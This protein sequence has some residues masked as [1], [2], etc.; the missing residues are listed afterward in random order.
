MKKEDKFIF[1]TNS[2]IIKDLLTQY[3]NT[4]Y[5]FCELINN[6]IQAKAN[7]IDIIIDYAKS[8]LTKVFKMKKN[9]F[10]VY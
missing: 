2:R 5:A 7:K 10:Q 1:S 4:F 9:D 8:D 3:R 6:S